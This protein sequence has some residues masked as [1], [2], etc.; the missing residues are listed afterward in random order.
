MAKLHNDGFGENI[1]T[2]EPVSN[3]EITAVRAQL[4][5]YITDNVDLQFAFDWVDDTSGVRGAKLLAPNRHPLANLLNPGLSLLP[6]LD[7]RYDVRNG[8][9]NINDTSVKGA[10]ATANVRVNDNWNAKYILAKRESDSETNI[11]FDTTQASS[12][13][14]RR[15]TATSR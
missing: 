3:K 12:P 13:T 7:S 8:M 11:D 4:G 15:S 6:V 9:P 14:S 1:V 10:S 5:A 2:G